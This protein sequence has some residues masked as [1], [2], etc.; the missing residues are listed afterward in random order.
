MTRSSYSGAASARSALILLAVADLFVLENIV[1][2]T[3]VGEG[4]LSSLTFLLQLPHL[5]TILVALLTVAYNRRARLILKVLFAV[6]VIA[7]LFD[8]FALVL[9]AIFVYKAT[10]ALEVRRQLVYCLQLFGMLLIDALG[11]H[12]V[13]RLRYCY[14][15]EEEALRA[16][17]PTTDV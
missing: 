8:T 9:H 16:L 2:V 7:F 6:F 10:T 11:A 5:F 17:T 13:E 14:T 4:T 15:E 1:A 3:V 12:F